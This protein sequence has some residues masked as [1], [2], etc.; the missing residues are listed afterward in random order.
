MS[1]QLRFRRGSTAEHAAFTGALAEVTVNTTTKSL[2]VHDG[3]TP[4][5]FPVTGT[6]PFLSYGA[7]PTG[8]LDST[9]AL[10]SAIAAAKATGKGYVDI[11]KGRFRINAGAVAIDS[12]VLRGAGI[13]EMNGVADAGSIFLLDS[14]TVTPFILGTGWGMEGLTFY[15]PNQTGTSAP[16][17]YPP[18][19]TGTYCAGAVMNNCHVVNAYQ[20]FKFP[21]GVAIG[22][23]RLHQ[24]RIYGIDKVFWFTTGVPEVLHISECLFSHGVFTLASTPNT[25]LRDHTSLSGEF[26]TI[27]VGG[28]AHPSIDGLSIVDSIIFGYR[29]GLRIVSGLLNVSNIHDTWFDQVGTSLS[30]EGTARVANSRWQSN[31]HWTSRQGFADA[32]TPTM[33]FTSSASSQMLISGNDFAYGHA[34]HIYAVSGLADLVITDNRFAD[35]GKST[36]ATPQP[37]CAVLYADSTSVVHISGNSFKATTGAVAHLRIGIS[38]TNSS[39]ATID[40]NTFHGCH[41]GI[42]VVNGGK[43]YLYSNTVS[44]GTSNPLRNDAASGVVESKNNKWGSAAVVGPQGKALC[45]VRGATQTFTGAKTVVAFGAGEVQDTDSNF[46]S[47]V[48]TCAV[49]GDYDVSVVLANT[50]GLTVADVWSLSIEQGGSASN[51]FARGTYVPA[52]AVLAAGLACR[53]LFS[54]AVGDTITCYVTRAAGAGNYVSIND[55]SYNYITVL[56]L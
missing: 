41:Y 10:V 20:V 40:T 49:A 28:H 39:V 3:T 55:A 12:V 29:Y 50:V 17:V 2:H 52:N 27:D 26:M 6:D 22:D 34:G 23:I 11:P 13:P 31:Y 4:G 24:C 32:V 43:V 21:A 8:V 25:Y 19:F 9:A 56:G 5:G 46:A 38:N 33:S 48:F 15:Y 30:V 45:Y 37:Y 1:T 53:G 36:Y 54:M 35:W 51:V 18:L 14:T 16:T 44:A 47:N 42:W 7:D